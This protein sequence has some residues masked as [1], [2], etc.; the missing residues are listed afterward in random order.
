MKKLTKLNSLF[1]LATLMLMYSCQKSGVTNSS[2]KT[3]I[4]TLSIVNS[5][6]ILVSDAATTSTTSSDAVY[7][8][9]AYTAGLAVDSVTFASL[10]TS[11]ATYLTTNY[12]GYTFKKAYQVLTTAKTIDSYVVVIQF[13]GKPVGLKFDANGVFVKV[14]EQCEGHDLGSNQPWHDAVVLISGTV[15]SMIR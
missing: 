14:L 5:Q 11:I 13:N 1:L 8:I 12:S 10:P 3:S 15:C 9:H 6:A 4:S 2:D 7:V